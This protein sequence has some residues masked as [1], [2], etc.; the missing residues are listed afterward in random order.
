MPAYLI[1][2]RETPVTDPEAIAE[3]SRRN[4]ENAATSQTQFA[5]LPRVVYGKVEALEGAAPDGVV[6][7]E[8]PTIE[9][10]RGW[11][12]SDAY[13]QAIPFREKAAKWRVVL[14]E[15]LG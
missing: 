7:L 4:R 10:A 3:Y 9:A 6:M 14:V 12:E 5:A 2:Y 11:Y 13:Q 1:V 15:G 8:F